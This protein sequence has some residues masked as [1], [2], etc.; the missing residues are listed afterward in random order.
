MW[1]I[2]QAEI[3]YNQRLLLSMMGLML[4]LSAYE[5]LL[6]DAPGFLLLIIMFMLMQSWVVGRNREK[7]EFQFAFC[8][9]V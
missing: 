4:P 9:S 2:L 7:R 1:K 8:L 3:S 5:I 6:P